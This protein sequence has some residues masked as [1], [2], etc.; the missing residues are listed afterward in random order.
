MYEIKLRYEDLRK[1]ITCVD[2]YKWRLKAMI[3]DAPGLT[4]LFEEEF[5]QLDR[6]IRK[7]KESMEMRDVD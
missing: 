5:K 3:A 4:E 2:T 1:L 6:I 7:A